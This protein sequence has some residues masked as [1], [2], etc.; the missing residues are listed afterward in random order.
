VQ[1]LKD[2]KNYLE[3]SESELD[4]SNLE[5]SPHNVLTDSIK[6]WK[7]GERYRYE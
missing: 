2:F 4:Q 6:N 5:P 1:K 3:Q 7:N